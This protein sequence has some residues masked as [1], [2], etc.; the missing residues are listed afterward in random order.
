MTVGY[1]MPSLLDLIP[2]VGS[3]P[4]RALNHSCHQMLALFLNPKKDTIVNGHSP[5]WRG[6]AELCG[7]DSLELD[8]FAQLTSPM[9]T[10][11]YQ[12]KTKKEATIGLFVEFVKTLERHDVLEDEAL[13]ERFV[14]DV[15]KYKESQEKRK[16]EKENEDPNKQTDTSQQPSKWLTISEVETGI[17]E[18]FDAFV[19]YSHTDFDWVRTMMIELENKKGLKLCIPGRD[20]MAGTSKYSAIAQLIKDRCRK[21][22]IIISP[23]YN[24]SDECDFQTHYAHALAPGSRSKRLIPV[25][26]KSEV[27]IPEVL[28]PVTLLDY[29][30]RD[31]IDWFWRN[32]AFSILDSHATNPDYETRAASVGSSQEFIEDIEEGEI[33][34]RKLTEDELKSDDFAIEESPIPQIGTATDTSATGSLGDLDLTIHETQPPTLPVREPERQAK[35][36]PKKSMISKFIGKFRKK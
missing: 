32:L 22:V 30:R 23:D 31:L 13:Y 1:G 28:R 24:K 29:T 34:I 6:I 36:E 2:E 21:M 9:D 3:L 27:T 26:I 16:R 35:P 4:F 17:P 18:Y 7:F 25:V 33:Q 12:W 11:L 5:D 10:I 14:G 8:N 19:C 15:M 20:L